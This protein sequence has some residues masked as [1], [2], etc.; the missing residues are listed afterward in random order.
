MIFK[1]DT[2]IDLKKV[3]TVFDSYVK[4]IGDGKYKRFDDLQICKYYIKSNSFENMD[5]RWLRLFREIIILR[6]Q[7]DK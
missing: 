2:K 5:F 4:G 7:R 1:N 6:K 3:E